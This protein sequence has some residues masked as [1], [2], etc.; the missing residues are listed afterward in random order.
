[1]N[2][3]DRAAQI[4]EALADRGFA[5]VADWLP[6]DQVVALAEEA[7]ALSASGRFK[8]AGVGRGAGHAVR[9]DIRG[10]RILWLDE[11]APTPAQARYWAAIEALRAALNRELYLGLAYFEAH[12]AIYPPG[13]HYQKHVD[14]FSDADERVISCSMYLNRAWREEHGGQLRLHLADGHPDGYIDVVP[15]AGTCVLF[16][17]DTFPHEVLPA[18]QARLSVTGWFRRRQAGPGRLP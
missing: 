7:R 5:I 8:P 11:Q 16:R 15:A 17:S 3:F 2:P 13:A 1:M 14:R 9:E 10:D 4:A 12:Y 6:P 18:T